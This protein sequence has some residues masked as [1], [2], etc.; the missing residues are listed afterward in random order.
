M[1]DMNDGDRIV[2]GAM[3]HDFDQARWETFK[4]PD[5]EAVR[6]RMNKVIKRL[7]NDL[8]R[9]FGDERWYQM[10]AHLLGVELSHMLASPD[11]P[12]AMHVVNNW[13]L[14]EP[15]GEDVTGQFGDFVAQ[16]L[17]MPE[18]QAQAV[19]EK[20]RARDAADKPVVN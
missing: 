9:Q 5:D 1:S 4:L 16:L 3:P 17:T 7:V 20:A 10:Y 8:K 12:Y 11:G 19:R 2:F 18:A 14:T 13:L 15:L 6:D